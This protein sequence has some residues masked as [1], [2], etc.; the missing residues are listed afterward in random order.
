MWR[1]IPLVAMLACAVGCGHNIGDPCQN[2]VDCNPLGDRF[3]DTASPG[4]YCTQENCDNTSCPGNSVCIRF[5]TP[6]ADESCTVNSATTGQGCRPDERCVCDFSSGGQCRSSVGHCAPT[7]TERRWCQARC[8]NNSDCRSGYECRETGTF[9][10][11]P[12][13]TFDDMSG[14]ESAKFCAP[15]RPTS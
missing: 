6:L 1:A 11:E 13:P 14:G 5:F 7:A 15:Q 3:C 10:A 9:G 2:N 4:G 8:S 12:V